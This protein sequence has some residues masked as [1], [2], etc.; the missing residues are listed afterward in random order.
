MSNR[1]Q[2]VSRKLSDPDFMQALARR[3]FM[4]QAV[5]AVAI[6][7]LVADRIWI[8]HHPPQPQFFYTDGHGTPYEVT[9]LDVPVMSDAEVLTWAVQSIVAAYSV[10]FATYRDTLSKAA[11]HFSNEGWNNFGS[12][13]IKTGNLDQIKRARLTVTAQPERAAT[14]LDRPV[15]DG[16]YSYK[17][18]FPMIVTYMNENQKITQHLMVDAVVMRSLVTSHPDGMVIDRINTTPISASAGG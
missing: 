13:F 3:S 7:G 18:Q 6:V 5:M 15:V 8:G 2:A 16:R 11:S 1:P 4:I 9:P 12:D 17:I 10:N 14:I